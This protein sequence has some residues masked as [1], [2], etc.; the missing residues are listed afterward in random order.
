M[1]IKVED[2]TREQ[3]LQL[4]FAEKSNVPLNSPTANCCLEVNGAL[5]IFKS[6]GKFPFCFLTFLHN[7]TPAEPELGPEWIFLTIIYS[8][9][10]LFQALDRNGEKM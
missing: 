1:G 4:S 3:Q 9:V 8:L 7:G 6:L 10:L 2:C 5:K